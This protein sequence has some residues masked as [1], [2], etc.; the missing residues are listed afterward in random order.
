MCKTYIEDNS[1]FYIE[2]KDFDF[3]LEDLISMNDWEKWKEC[4]NYLMDRGVFKEDIS[5]IRSK[6]KGLYSTLKGLD[7]PLTITQLDNICKEVNISWTIEE[8]FYLP[9]TVLHVNLYGRSNTDTYTYKDLRLQFTLCRSIYTFHYRDD[10]DIMEV[11]INYD[12]PEEEFTVFNPNS[13]QDDKGYSV[14]ELVGNYDNIVYT[15]NL[16]NFKNINLDQVQ[17]KYPEYQ[18]YTELKSIQQKLK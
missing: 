12:I 6:F 3:N 5:S 13:F 2:K 16:N 1:M 9:T 4:S 7:I 17:K 18:Y 14:D 15:L 11:F 10:F 8:R